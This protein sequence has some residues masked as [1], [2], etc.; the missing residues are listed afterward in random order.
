VLKATAVLTPKLSDLYGD[1]HKGVNARN[2]LYNATYEVLL[3]PDYLHILNCICNFEVKKQF[4]CY[5]KD[6]YV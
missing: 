3:P 2:S 1:A 5:D 6:T 4:K